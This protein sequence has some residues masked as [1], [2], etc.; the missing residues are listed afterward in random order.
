[1]IQLC[2]HRAQKEAGLLGQKVVQVFIENLFHSHC[3]VICSTET[4]NLETKTPVA[5]EFST[6]Y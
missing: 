3:F 4:S 1:M 6:Y 2:Q 5:E